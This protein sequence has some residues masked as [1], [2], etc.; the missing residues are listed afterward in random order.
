MS[1][2][3]K[4]SGKKPL[5]GHRVS[6]S[7]IKTNRWQK[8]NMQSKRICDPELGRTVRLRVSVNAIRSITRV[9]LS[10]YLRKKNL[11]LKDVI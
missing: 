4:I 3:C 5:S 7:N 9:G 6:K 2:K 8:L 11:K 10:V 1:R